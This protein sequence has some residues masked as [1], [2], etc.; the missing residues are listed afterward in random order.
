VKVAKVLPPFEETSAEKSTLHV[1]S[2]V[3]PAGGEGFEELGRTKHHIPRDDAIRVLHRTR[4]GVAAIARRLKVGKEAGV[5][6][7]RDLTLR[8][9]WNS[10]DGH[11]TDNHQAGKDRTEDT[12]AQE[13]YGG[14]HDVFREVPVGKRQG[15]WGGFRE[16]S[17]RL[18]ILRNSVGKCQFRIAHSR[19]RRLR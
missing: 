8:L 13:M 1:T 3:V 18:G 11:Q 5:V 17:L 4:T 14:F 10:R 9:R 19:R 2:L 15:I 12:L 16:S 7:R 6:R